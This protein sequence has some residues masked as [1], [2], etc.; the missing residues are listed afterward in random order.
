MVIKLYILKEHA[1]G[2]YTRTE[3]LVEGTLEELE[4][5][6]MMHKLAESIG[7][8][9]IY[10]VDTIRDYYSI[11]FTMGIQ[12]CPQL[13]SSWYDKAAFVKTNKYRKSTP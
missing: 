8:Y 5:T 11:D 12:Q 9:E 13:H 10:N 6:A 3:E 7:G 2:L 4:Q 1:P